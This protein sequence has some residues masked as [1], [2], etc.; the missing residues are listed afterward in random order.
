MDI[1]RVNLSLSLFLVSLGFGTFRTPHVSSFFHV[2]KEER[3]SAKTRK[4]P[5]KHPISSSDSVNQE[6]SGRLKS[7]AYFA[8]WLGERGGG[9]QPCSC[10]GER[11]RHIKI[12]RERE[13]E[14]ERKR[15]RERR[16]TR[17]RDK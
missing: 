12:D 5:F 14:R 15:E 10:L 17:E 2:R 7:R 16:I 13:R 3:E 6:K 1:F 8:A 4:A 11:E 9:G